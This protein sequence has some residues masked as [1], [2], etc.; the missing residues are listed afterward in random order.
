M[1]L[2]LKPDVSLG[3]RAKQIV[4]SEIDDSL[5]DLA[6][7]SAP[8]S[9]LDDVVH[10]VRKRCKKLRAVLRLV[11]PCLGAGVYRFENVDLR[12]TARPL[13]EV[14]DS[15]ALIESLDKLT[16]QNPDLLP[17]TA[18]ADLREI[19]V[20][21]R[22][23]AS[24]QLLEPVPVC[25]QVGLRLREAR[26]RLRDW[27]LKRLDWPQLRD[28]LLHEFDIGVE[29]YHVTKT[30]PTAE[31]LHEWR[32]QVKYLLNQLQVLRPVWRGA[33]RTL[34]RDLD[35]LAE[36]LGDDHDLSQLGQAVTSESTNRGL[37]SDLEDLSLAIEDRR[38]E[39]ER[40]AFVIGERIYGQSRKTF[41]RDLNHWWKS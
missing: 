26:V 21:R 15:D 22:E 10:E 19:L 25:D 3:R 29:A 30:Q 9:K 31:Q 16:Q 36:I 6:E 35:E 5:S 40:Q 28:R 37:N 7:I 12:E 34:G 23:L 41:R 2:R 18:C 39:L 24:R 14:R 13:R 11:R 32:K 1:S 33:K 4:R 8:D 27:K 20:N 38:Q 17:S